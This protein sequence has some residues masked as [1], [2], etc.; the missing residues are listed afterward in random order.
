MKYKGW[1]YSGLLQGY[2]RQGNG[3]IRRPPTKPW[4]GNL[5]IDKIMSAK[6]ASWMM[7]GLLLPLNLKEIRLSNSAICQTLGMLYSKRK[8]C[9]NN[10]RTSL[11]TSCF[12]SFASIQEIFV[13]QLIPPTTQYEKLLTTE[14]I[15]M[16]HFTKLQPLEFLVLPSV[17]KI[18]DNQQR[19]NSTVSSKLLK[20]SFCKITTIHPLLFWRSSLISFS[21]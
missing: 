5:E 21:F 8:L 13:Y 4:V 16:Q 14:C 12:K 18:S 1:R 7:S 9:L 6:L 10:F 19:L 3:C 2:K 17:G 20:T 11:L 15:S